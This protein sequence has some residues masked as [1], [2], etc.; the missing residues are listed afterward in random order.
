MVVV[1]VVD[2]SL[3]L[4]YIVFVYNKST[5]ER[6]H[7]HTHTHIFISYHSPETEIPGCLALVLQVTDRVPLLLDAGEYCI[8]FLEHMIAVLLLDVFGEWTEEIKCV[9]TLLWDVV[10]LESAKSVGTWDG[11]CC[12]GVYVC[13]CVFF[14]FWCCWR[15]I[16]LEAAKATNFSSRKPKKPKMQQNED[17]S[18]RLSGSIL[19]QEHYINPVVMAGGED[20]LNS[21]ATMLDSEQQ[22]KQL[23][24]LSRQST[25]LGE[26]YAKVVDDESAMGGHSSRTQFSSMQA[27]K[28]HDAR[29]EIV[30]VV[31][32]TLE[33]VEQE[34]E[35]ILTSSITNDDKD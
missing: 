18:F 3:S 12:H 17:W 32:E 30:Q 15:W 28:P 23:L 11:R 19:G 20:L 2:R 4:I 22:H 16:V 25:A 8:V 26:L 7:I 27:L 34:S 9:E 14:A 35:R 6:T 29:K 31:K 33:H 24:L 10:E 5:D 1:V 21:Q 13:M